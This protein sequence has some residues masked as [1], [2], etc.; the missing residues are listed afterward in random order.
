[1]ASK[2]AQRRH[3]CTRKKPYAT[4]AEA[5]GALVGEMRSGR[6]APGVLSVYRCRSGGAHFHIGHA[7][8]GKYEP[9]PN[10]YKALLRGRVRLKGVAA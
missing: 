6:V 3:E 5:H 2:R 9:T 1:M 7:P 4:E 8:A 10:Q